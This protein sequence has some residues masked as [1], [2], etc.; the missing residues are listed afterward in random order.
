M[1]HLIGDKTWR[2]TNESESRLSASAWYLLRNWNPTV[3]SVGY[4]QQALL[5]RWLLPETIFR[6]REHETVFASLGRG[7]WSCL[8]WPMVRQ[9]TA[10]GTLFTFCTEDQMIIIIITML[11]KFIVF[12]EHHNHGSWI[13]IPIKSMNIIIMGVGLPFPLNLW[14]S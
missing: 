11:T 14:T 8:V 2:T 4:M 9:V 12:Q 5:S 7:K 13:A 3:H 10:Q 1:S 6:R